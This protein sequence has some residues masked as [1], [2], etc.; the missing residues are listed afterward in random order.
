MSSPDAEP[1]RRYDAFGDECAGETHATYAFVC[2]A[3]PDIGTVVAALAEIRARHGLGQGA[4][5][6]RQLFSADQRRRLGLAHLTF[7]DVLEIYREVALVLAAEAAGLTVTIA[8]LR[9]FPTTQPA[10]DPFPRIVFGKKQLG[11]FC[12]HAA[13]LPL[14]H[15]IR[16]Q[17]LRFWVDRDAT[18][19]EWMGGFR[20]A[21]LA[22]GGYV[23]LGGE[24]VR[25]TP[26]DL[27][28]LEDDGRRTLFQAAD[29]LAWSANRVQGRARSQTAR[30]IGR[31]Y[32]LMQPRELR[33]E[34]GLDGGMRLRT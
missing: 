17:D 28:D 6:C 14:L 3:E 11:V 25:A 33:L 30:Q 19:M 15:A 16:D 31:V 13:T 32:D 12:A 34:T 21:S 26:R 29:F 23:N 8:R 2:F 24:A 27:A 10:A 20:Q 22:I 1:K 5:H 4:L 9:D 18:R 7:T